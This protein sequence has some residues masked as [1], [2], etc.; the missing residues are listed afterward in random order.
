MAE[1][2]TPVGD[3]TAHW[4]G[5]PDDAPGTYTVEWTI[6]TELAWG[7][8]ARPSPTPGP[9][10][11]TGGGCTVRRGQL[12]VTVDGIG[13]LHL[14][15]TS[16]LLDLAAPLPQSAVATWVDFEVTPEEIGLYPYFP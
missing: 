7:Q 6:D 15:D 9:A 4:C 16:V 5:K 11:L 13:V 2:R 14:G 12:D 8:N 10:L 1:V 3:L